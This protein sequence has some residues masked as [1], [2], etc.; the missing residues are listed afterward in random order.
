MPRHRCPAVLIAG[1][2]ILAGAQLLSAQ[3]VAPFHLS[4]GPARL[5]PL[6]GVTAWPMGSLRLV[7]SN[8]SLRSLTTTPECRMPVVT[9]NARTLERMP[10]TP[11]D[12]S[13][14]FI[15]VVPPGCTNPL[16]TS[17]DTASTRP[18]VSHR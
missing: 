16:A 5:G 18:H 13:A 8:Y 1:P 6:M 7:A 17:T 9:P 4:P 15:Q 3:G 2:L 12:A 11:V 14:F 10:A